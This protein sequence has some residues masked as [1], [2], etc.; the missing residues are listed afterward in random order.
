MD[1]VLFDQQEALKNRGSA[2]GYV[3]DGLTIAQLEK[4][5][6]FVTSFRTSEIE[7]TR[8]LQG[9]V[10]GTIEKFFMIRSD[11][12]RDMILKEGTGE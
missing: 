7:I 5:R 8:G 4:V 11:E 2:A 12:L 10:F 6:V 3:L 9:D 1:N